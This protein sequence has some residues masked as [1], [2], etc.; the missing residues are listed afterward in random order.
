[1]SDQDSGLA[2]SLLNIGQQIGGSIGLAVL[3]T[4]AWSA[5]ATNLRQQAA[6]AAR[7]AAVAGQSLVQAS[8]VLSKTQM[9]DH[10]LAVGFTRGFEV[11]AAIAMLAVVVVVVMIRSR[12]PPTD[13]E[14]EGSPAK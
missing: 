2:S 9:R 5:V 3:G 4:V 13:A 11:A 6:A 14:S 1:V 10:A 8:G 7:A 12:E